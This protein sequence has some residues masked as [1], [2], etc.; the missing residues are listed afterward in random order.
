MV[1]EALGDP[2][3][4][5]S[6]CVVVIRKGKKNNNQRLYFKRITFEVVAK[7]HIRVSGSSYPLREFLVVK[8]K[9]KI[10]LEKN[11]LRG[12]RSRLPTSLRTCLASLR[13]FCM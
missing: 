11:E 12:R 1:P 2:E 5:T 3:L 8:R 6:C 4:C 9:T 13:V 7:G 10:L